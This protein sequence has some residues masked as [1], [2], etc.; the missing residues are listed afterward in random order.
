[1]SSF[2]TVK[3]FDNEL[4][5]LDTYATGISAVHDVVKRASR[6]HAVKNGLMY[7]LAFGILVPALYYGSYLVI[8]KPYL[9]VEMGAVATVCSCFQ[10]ISQGIAMTLASLDDLFKASRSAAKLLHV[11]D[12]QPQR[13]RSA[14]ATLPVVRGKIEFRS[15]DFKYQSREDYAVRDLSFTIE[16]GETVALVGE[17]GCGKSTTLQLI[18]RFYDIQKGTILIDDVDIKTLS[19][20][21]VRSQISSVPQGPVLFSMS[22]SDNI[23][24]GKHDATEEEVTAAARIGNAHDFV[25]ELPENYDTS[26]AQMSLSGGQKQRL[27]ISRAI[28]ENAPILLLD[29]ATAALDTESEQLVHQSLEQYRHGKTA[30]VVAHR[31]ATVKDANRILVFRD[32]GIAESGTHNELLERSGLYSDLVRFQFQ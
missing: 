13:D 19:P 1:M 29:E 12:K 2:R 27:C 9:G 31:L 15:V 16:S 23:R 14:G 30:I 25:M 22:V 17:S 20:V 11:L 8:K 5:E 10:G 32:G 3:S 4:Y 28:L 26:V 7:F 24:F 18:Q 6:V 21:F